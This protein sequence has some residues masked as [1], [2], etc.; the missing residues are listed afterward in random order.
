MKSDPEIVA[1]ALNGAVTAVVLL[2]DYTLPLTDPF[3]SPHRKGASCLLVPRTCS[4]TAF[5]LQ[6]RTSRWR[7]GKVS[8]HPTPRAQVS[9]R[10]LHSEMLAKRLQ[11]LASELEKLIPVKGAA[12]SGLVLQAI[13][14]CIEAS[15]KVYKLDRDQPALLLAAASPFTP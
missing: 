9:C 1:A 12:E 13:G 5:L 7:G 14:L 11:P 15:I 4:L 8:C 6:L 2:L 10:L 3:T